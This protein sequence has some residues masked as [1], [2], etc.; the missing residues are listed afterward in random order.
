MAAAQSGRPGCAAAVDTDR[1]LGVSLTS[2]VADYLLPAGR[3]GRSEKV[4]SVAQILASSGA[5]YT[6][7]Q[8]I[9]VDGGWTVG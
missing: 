9:D 3:N 6:N 4:A 2:D 8:T 7:G 1:E 5:S